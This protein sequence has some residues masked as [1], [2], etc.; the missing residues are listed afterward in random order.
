MPHYV[1]RRY[2]WLAIVLGA[3]AAQADTPAPD[4]S[5]WKCEQCPFL[6][7][8]TAEAEAG[9]LYADGAN[10]SYGRYSGMDHNGVYADVGAKGQWGSSNDAYVSYDLENL[11]LPSRDGSIDAGRQGRYDVRVTYDGQP[12][13]LYDTTVT[14]FVGGGGQLSLPANWVAAGSTGGMTQLDSSLRSVDI[15]TNRRTVALSGRF[16]AGPA[17]TVFGEFRHQEKDGTGIIGGS[18]L[19]DAAQLPQPID[20]VTNSFEAGVSWMGRIASLHVAYIGSWFSDNTDSLTWSN[21]YL[22]IV[23]A[24]TDGRLSLP[25]DNN[26]QQLS[27]SGEIRLPVFT[28]TTLTYN[29][30]F[31]RMKQN[32]EFLPLS[33][34]PGAAL[35]TPDS[36]DADVRTSHYALGLASRPLSRLYIRGTAKYDGRD[37]HTS[38]LAIAYFAT[39]ALPGGTYLTPRYGDNRTHLDGSAD[40][41]LFSWARIGVGG[42]Y[43]DVHYAPGQVLTSTRETRG[44]GYATF[45]PLASLSVTVKGGSGNRDASSFDAGALPSTENPLLRTFNYAPRDRTFYTLSGAWE[46]ASTLS[47]AVEGSFANDTYRLSQLGMQNGHDR[48]IST[49]L[50]WTPDEKLNL[51][52][53]G[54]YQRVTAQQRGTNQ[55]AAPAWTATVA[56][57]YWS[58]GTG[59]RWTINARWDMKL[60][61]VTSNATV[62]TDVLASGMARSFP[63]NRMRLDSLRLSTTYLWTPALQA[64]LRYGYEKYDSDD[65]AFDDVAPATVPNLLAL[66]AQPWRHRVNVIGLGVLYRIGAAADV[67]R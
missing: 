40:Y 53:N 29:A 6:R 17:W 36:L 26:L 47:W 32:A 50:A 13:R 55:P 56:Q 35:L 62:D 24:A 25:P 15:E 67:A 4:T 27:A 46:L 8:H 28:A 66:G 33:T 61:Y 45:N 59:G 12:S 20:Y 41:R 34:L 21:P 58:A 54:G 39:D 44:W 22:P 9:A 64:R 51:Y 23:P 65:W 16:F 11:G 60:D 7:G 30:S 19:T 37:D 57:H 49:T 31:G 1:L 63:E 52:V 38:P 18:F 10:A 2:V 42:D 5:G 3:A 48:N 43:L 14:P